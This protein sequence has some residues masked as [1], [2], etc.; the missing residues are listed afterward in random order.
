MDIISHG[1]QQEYSFLFQNP[2]FMT[3]IIE[4]IL[5]IIVEAYIYGITLMVLL[6][7]TLPSM[8]LILKINKIESFSVFFIL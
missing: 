4:R 8:E 1:A 6:R 7:V 5:E 2:P 3:I